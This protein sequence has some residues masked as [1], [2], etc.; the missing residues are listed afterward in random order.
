[1]SYFTAAIAAAL[2]AGSLAGPLTG[3]SA[4]APSAAAPADSK[5]HAACAKPS[6][7]RAGCL[8]TVAAVGTSATDPQPFTAADLQA[9]YKLPS[10]R[11]GGGET[12]AVVVPYSNPNAE[13]D[14]GVYRAANGLPP[15]TSDFPCFRRV[16]QRGESTPPAIVPTWSLNGATAL[17]MASAACPNCKLLL[18]EADDNGV[19]NLGQAVAQAA[20]QGATVITTPYGFVEYSGALADGSYYDQPGVPITA[21]SGNNGFGN[22]VGKQLVPAA[23]ATVTAVGGTALYR[24][25]SARGWAETTWSG[26]GSGCSVYLPKPAWQP[27]GAC[28]TKRTVADTAAVADLNTPVA[29]YDSYGN[30]GW[31]AS[32]GTP[33]AAALVAG[34][35]AL[36]GNGDV[37]TP[38]KQLYANGGRLFDVTTGSNGT[39]AAAELCKA[40][41]GYDGPTGL[42][43]PNG[44]GAF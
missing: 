2:L 21:P 40:R 6:G 28:G 39:C 20:K 23:Y 1:M 33:A 13:A 19:K 44:I 16:N 5:P 42:G 12:I 18:V 34:V 41:K 31:V 14:L 22:T 4:A 36:A 26:S 32:A 3:P 38:G 24:D 8:L 15:C 35:Y 7:G 10:A 29:V 27:K 9:A 17:D 30:G 25:S 37:I 43:T 11:L